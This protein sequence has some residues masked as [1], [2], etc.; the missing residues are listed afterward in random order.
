MMKQRPFITGFLR[1]YPNTTKSSYECPRP[2]V[3]GFS[4]SN[5]VSLNP[6]ARLAAKLNGGLN[7]GAK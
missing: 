7:R 3:Q 5:S 2:V 4:A 6:A 1:P